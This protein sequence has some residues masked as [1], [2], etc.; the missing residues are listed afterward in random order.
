L[1]F[2]ATLLYG[3]LLVSAPARAVGYDKIERR[4][5][6]EP[7]YRT[8]SP[9]YALL[10]F[11]PEA[12]LRVWLVMDGEVLYVDRNGNGD[13]TERG[14]RFDKE[15]ACKDVIISDPDGKT[16]YVIKSVKSDFSTYTAAARRKREAEGILPELLVTVEIKGP[17][18]YWRARDRATQFKQRCHGFDIEGLTLH[19]YCDA[20]AGAGAEV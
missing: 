4:L 3:F 14:E 7:A 20:W 19:L 9:N 15:A 11:G 16:K 12:R 13:L 2:A 10:L 1:R 17:V 8:K 5:V 6:K 18:D